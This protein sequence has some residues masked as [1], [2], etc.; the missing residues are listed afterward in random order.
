M[1]GIEFIRD[2]VPQSFS[3]SWSLQRVFSYLTKVIAEQR[4]HK[5]EDTRILKE[6]CHLRMTTHETHDP[7]ID[8][9]FCEK[10]QHQDEEKHQMGA[11]SEGE[12]LHCKSRGAANVLRPR[13]QLPQ[14]AACL[15]LGCTCGA[16][17][18][19]S[20]IGSVVHFAPW[21]E[22]PLLVWVWNTMQLCNLQ[23]S[24]PWHLWQIPQQPGALPESP[25]LKNA[26][27]VILH[28]PDWGAV[29]SPSF[30]YSELHH[31]RHSWNLL[32][33]KELNFFDECTK[34]IHCI[35]KLA[36][37]VQTKRNILL[38]ARFSSGRNS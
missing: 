5:I 19:H 8:I 16:A 26:P 20:C 35:P 10:Q 6:I 23:G 11:V 30:P 21:S 1:F 38:R 25:I 33:I 37:K 31:R 18:A 15:A 32:A 13:E 12:T 27:R 24:L 7:I 22:L 29:V 2:F 28:G 34:S 4:N 17:V 14:A 3:K 9:P 36:G